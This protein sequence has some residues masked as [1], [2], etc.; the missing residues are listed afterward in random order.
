MSKKNAQE[1]SVDEI[2]RQI[3]AEVAKRKAETLQGR[4]DGIIYQIPENTFAAPKMQESKLFR[5]VKKIQSWLRSYPFFDFVNNKA[6]RL[7]KYIPKYRERSFVADFLLYHDREFVQNVYRGICK[8]EPDIQG[9]ENYLRKLREG[10]LSKIEI[11]GRVRYS[12]EGREKGVRV[13][14]LLIRYVVKTFFRIPIIGYIANMLVSLMRLPK[15]FIYIQ[16]LESFTTTNIKHIENQMLYTSRLQSEHR[17][18]IDDILEVMTTRASTQ[19][20]DEI[21]KDLTAKA[22]AQSVDEIRKDL[23]AKAS[24]QS[25]DEIR[26]DL[27]AKADMLDVRNLRSEMAVSLKT[28]EDHKTHI[29]SELRGLIRLFESDNRIF[30]QQMSITQVVELRKETN[31][32][33]DDLYLAFENQFRGARQDIKERLK[34]YLPYLIQIESDTRHAPVLDIGCGRGEWLEVLKEQGIIAKGIDINRSMIQQ[35]KEFGLDVVEHDAIEYIKSQPPD[36][37]SVVTGFHVVEHLPVQVLIELID[38]TLTALTHEGIV[39]FES[40]NPEN[41]IVGS[42]NFYLDPTHIHPIVP[43]TLKFLLSAR[44]FK[45]TEIL[46]LN[47]RRELVQTGNVP[48]DEVIERFNTAMD[49]AVIGHKS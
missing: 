39:I 25:V 34:V 43:D 40:P 28:I 32:I 26:K 27:T 7:K 16:Q 41:T 10:R 45:R 20:V 19:S 49:Y 42:C 1:V 13:K 14:G 22:S 21:R 17:K 47:R 36:S 9:F 29:L 44:G 48:M 30:Q 23:T 31:H 12:R 4:Q 46:R 3:R 38:A 8:R 37:L 18:N 11:L 33:L 15:A 5:F 35:C 6:K 24:A 2:I